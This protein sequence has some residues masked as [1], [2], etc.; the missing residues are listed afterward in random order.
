MLAA[1][2]VASASQSANATVATHR[3]VSRKAT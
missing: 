1:R 2:T 3:M